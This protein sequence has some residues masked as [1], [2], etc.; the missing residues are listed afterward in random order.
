MDEEHRWGIDREEVL[1][2]NT[3]TAN[4]HDRMMK[5]I[6]VYMLPPKKCWFWSARLS[7]LLFSKMLLFYLPTTRLQRAALC[8]FF[9]LS[10]PFFLN[11]T[12]NCFSSPLAGSAED[13]L[14]PAQVV[15]GGT[16]TQT[17]APHVVFDL[18]LLHVLQRTEGPALCK[19]EGRGRGE[20]GLRSAGIGWRLCPSPMNS[21][22]SVFFFFP[23][24]LARLN[25][26]PCFPFLCP[27]TEVEQD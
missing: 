5:H 15:V 7:F 3:R 9:F 1:P 23:P 22:S 20:G 10:L 19:T 24:F 17:L 14:N 16:H 21:P 27:L 13:A 12:L 8:F 4:T 6:E 2:G 18:P 25:P 26:Q 11:V